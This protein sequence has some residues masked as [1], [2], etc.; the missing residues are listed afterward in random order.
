MVYR[1]HSLLPV[2]HRHSML[3][4]GSESLGVNQ[5][6][7]MGLRM[8]V[9]L[10]RGNLKHL[11][12]PTEAPPRMAASMPFGRSAVQTVGVRRIVERF[13]MQMASSGPNITTISAPLDII[14]PHILHLW[15]ARQ[16]D[17]QI[18]EDLQKCFDTSHYGLGTR[19]QGHTVNTVHD[20]M[21]NLHEMFPNA[22][23][24]EMHK[25]NH[26][27]RRQF[28][29]A[30]VNDL[31]AVNQHNKWLKY[32]LGLHTGIEP[33]SDMPMVTQSDPGSENFGIA[34]AH[35]MLRQWHDPA[36]QGTLQHCWMQSE[37][38]EM[39]EI[40]W[41]QLRCR[42]TLGFEALL[43]HGVLSGWY[44]TNNTLQLCLAEDFSALDFK[45]KVEH[46]A[47]DHVRNIYIKPSHVVFNL[48]PQPFGD[49]VQ[50]CYDELGS[51]LVTRH[52]VWDIYL[53][54]LGMLR[55]HDEIPHHIDQLDDIEEDLGTLLLLEDHN[56][57]PYR[58]KSNS[59][60]YMGG[61]G[62]G[63][64]LGIEH[65]NQL[66][67]LTHDDEP[68]I[69]LSVNENIGLDHAGLVMWEFSDG[70]GPDDVSDTPDADW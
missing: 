7:P 63:L 26:L 67:G 64:G 43:D 38:N 47:L 35:T 59:A 6:R 70:S 32:S 46:E 68:E 52:T 18:V 53:H 17:K 4:V 25:A 66:E 54:L 61:V 40:M 45:I 51:P 44:D 19:Q 12:D 20:A 56:K 22:G 49:C 34:N 27:L 36:L 10:Q 3:H 21:A 50:H 29:A 37:K 41:S 57:L 31:F 30:G 15:K 28:W 14:T 11:K 24:H 69:T 39:P 2:V 62:G 65:L 58:E 16:T 48:V 42:F 9:E 13:Q 23:A 60:Y 33:F 5:S 1:R 55:V 8:E